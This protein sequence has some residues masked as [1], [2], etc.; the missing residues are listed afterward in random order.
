MFPSASKSLRHVEAAVY[1]FEGELVFR[2]EDVAVL[3]VGVLGF[4]ERPKRLDIEGR[5]FSGQ[6][7]IG[8]DPFFYK[9]SLHKMTGIPSL[10][11]AWALDE[12]QL[13]TTPWRMDLV[14]GRRFLSRRD[15]V[16][17]SFRSVQRTDAW[18]DDDGHGH[19]VFSCTLKGPVG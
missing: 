14:D 15:D 17:H 9:E 5:W 6:I 12:I 19:Y 11:Y 1:E 3:D 4:R 13:E 7:Y 8:V 16:P 18:N 2:R 10:T